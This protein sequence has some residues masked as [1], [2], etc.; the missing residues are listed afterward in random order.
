MFMRIFQIAKMEINF[1]IKNF[2]TVEIIYVKHLLILKK[3][4]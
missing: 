1:Y 2:M 4:V 3:N